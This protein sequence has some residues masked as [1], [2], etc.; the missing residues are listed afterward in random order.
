MLE[1]YPFPENPYP[2]DLDGQIDR[3]YNDIG[4]T[5]EEQREQF[6]EE[7]MADKPWWGVRNEAEGR[8]YRAPYR[9]KPTLEMKKF[10]KAKQAVWHVIHMTIS[11]HTEPYKVSFDGHK[12]NYPT[13]TEAIEACERY[14]PSIY[15]TAKRIERGC[16]DV[17]TG[18]GEHFRL[19]VLFF[20]R[21]ST[22]Y[23]RFDR[24]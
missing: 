23:R 18:Y 10:R 20:G 1:Q 17:R 3:L 8:V 5:T 14:I 4:C 16:W 19:Q 6:R 15:P 24:E 13:E 22:S 21:K 2:D 7:R 9:H 11:G 12:T